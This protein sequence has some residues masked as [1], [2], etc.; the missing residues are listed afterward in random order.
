MPDI[1]PHEDAELRIREIAAS[2]GLPEPDEVIHHVDEEELE[3][4][5]YEQ[6][7]AVVIELNR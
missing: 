2:A 4:R 5:W 3:L 6:K 1:A 7:L